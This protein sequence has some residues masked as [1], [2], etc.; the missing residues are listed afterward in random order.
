[1]ITIT[2][3]PTLEDT[4]AKFQALASTGIYNSPRRILDAIDP[5]VLDA[6]K[7]EAPVRTG[8]L[9]QSIYSALSGGYGGSVSREYRA[10]GYGRYV[11]EG[12]NPHLIV[13]HGWLGDVGTHTMSRTGYL[14]F[15]SEGGDLVFRRYVN[16]PGTKPNPFNQ[17]ALTNAL[18]EVSAVA[19]D[20]FRDVVVEGM[21]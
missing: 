10:L 20:N 4:A 1:M 5:I 16:H 14:A 12:T 17:R 3:T 18:P 19:R 15:T 21:A 2:F 8:A 11:I 9:Q 13:A 7:A 6:L